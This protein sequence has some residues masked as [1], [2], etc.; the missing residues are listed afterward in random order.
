RPGR[1]GGAEP[2]A[3]GGE[4]W[5]GWVDRLVDACQRLLGSL[6]DLVLVEGG[7][8]A[9]WPEIVV[10]ERKVAPRGEVIARLREGF[11]PDDL[12]AAVT[13]LARWLAAVPGGGASRGAERFAGQPSGGRREGGADRAPR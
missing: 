3:A 9:G 2:R 12:E 13:A 4:A 1:A 8:G 11:G 7:A 5:T 6:P 10:G